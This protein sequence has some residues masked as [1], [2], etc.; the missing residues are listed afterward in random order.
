MF[1]KQKG[2]GAAAVIGVIALLA[3]V[4]AVIASSMTSS[5][6]KTDKSENKLLAAAVL[7]QSAQIKDAMQV[8][9]A[10]NPDIASFSDITL[11]SAARAVDIVTFAVTV[12][13]YNSIDGTMDEI[14]VPAQAVSVDQPWAVRTAGTVVLAGT[15]ADDTLLKIDDVMPDVCLA[16]NDSLRIPT[17]AGARSA[18]TTVSTVFCDED[19]NTFYQ[20]V[21]IN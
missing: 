10:Q 21:E 9:K 6:G 4:G 1:K 13:L 5:S 16:I 17:T 12:G 3:V 7:M 11:D 15:A 19:T 8:L 18:A 2:F 20:L 14:K